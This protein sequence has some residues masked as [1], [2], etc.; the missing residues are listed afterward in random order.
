MT[1]QF[2]RVMRL[3]A[4]AFKEGKLDMW[5]IYD[6]PKDYPDVFVARRFILDQATKDMFIGRTL[7]EIRQPFQLAGFACMKRAETDDPVI[8]E[9]WL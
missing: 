3:R 8:V 9:T 7:D 5:T 2:A 1:F 6:K 4:T